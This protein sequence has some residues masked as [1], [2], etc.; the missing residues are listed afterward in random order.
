MV[1]GTDTGYSLV[2]GVLVSVGAL[3]VV[4]LQ[5]DSLELNLN[6]KYLGTGPMRGGTHDVARHS[7]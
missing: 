4:M 2:I 3:E 5:I 1:I 6:R 7:A